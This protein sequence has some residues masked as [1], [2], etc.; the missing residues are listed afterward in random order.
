MKEH[1][2]ENTA[3]NAFKTADQNFD[4]KMHALVDL[5][6]FFHPEAGGSPSR[7]TQAWGQRMC[8]TQRETL[9]ALK[10]IF[11]GEFDPSSQDY[12]KT[13]DERAL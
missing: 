12:F 1:F 6:E 13:A 11:S 4:K 9:D 10:A 5:S 2:E 8:E 7:E 3:P